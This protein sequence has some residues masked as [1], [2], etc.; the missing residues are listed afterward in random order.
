MCANAEGESI[1]QDPNKV[2]T[3]SKIQ[4]YLQEGCRVDLKPTTKKYSRS[5]EY[6]FSVLEQEITIDNNIGII[7]RLTKDKQVNMQYS[8]G[9]GASMGVSL[10]QDINA[11]VTPIIIYS[12]HVGWRDQKNMLL[13]MVLYHNISKLCTRVLRNNVDTGDDI[14]LQQ[15]VLFQPR[16]LTTEPPIVYLPK[17][18]LSVDFY[19]QLY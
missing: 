12:Y 4:S 9:G 11:D 18:Q 14:P 7:H 13:P 19:L 15:Q 2:L 8:A 16:G 1:T 5:T 6:S 3:D 10:V 17:N